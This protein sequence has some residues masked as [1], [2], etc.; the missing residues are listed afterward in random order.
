MKTK[1]NQVLDIVNAGIGLVKAGQEQLG[2]AIQNGQK[3]LENFRD[4][5]QKT[6]SDIGN[7][8]QKVYQDLKTKGA[9]ESSKEASKVRELAVNAA[10]KIG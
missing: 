4:N 1:E 6:I 7:G 8:A 9:L 2:T 5:V 10:R 3:S